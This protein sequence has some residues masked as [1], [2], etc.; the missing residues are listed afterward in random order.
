MIKHLKGD[1]A[2]EDIEIFK[3]RQGASI[4]PNVGRSVGLSVCPWKKLEN[5]KNQKIKFFDYF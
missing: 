3:L 4:S 1:V 5:Q 2:F